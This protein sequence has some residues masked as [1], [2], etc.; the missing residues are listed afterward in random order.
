M[1]SKCKQLCPFLGKNIGLCSGVF[2]TVKDIEQDDIAF[3]LNTN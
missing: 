3:L 1:V 2:E